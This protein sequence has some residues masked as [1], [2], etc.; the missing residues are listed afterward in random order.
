MAH[1]KWYLDVIKIP[2]F[3]EP[4]DSCI[5]LPGVNALGVEV[6]LC[7]KQEIQIDGLAIRRDGLG[8]GTAFESPAP[9]ILVED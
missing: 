7:P 6:E 5:P 2:R 1:R 3:P 8:Q 9:S 4:C